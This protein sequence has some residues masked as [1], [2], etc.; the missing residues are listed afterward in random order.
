MCK[1]VD[2]KSQLRVEQCI[3]IL[4]YIFYIKCVLGST[5]RLFGLIFHTDFI[6]HSIYFYFFL[7]TPI[8]F[9]NFSFNWV[10]FMIKIM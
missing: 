10:N 9:Y 4:E 7:C 2:S 3:Y 6:L 1:I 8:S 5:E